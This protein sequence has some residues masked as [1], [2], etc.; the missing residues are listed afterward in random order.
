MDRISPTVGRKRMAGEDDWCE[1]H[2]ATQD[3]PGIQE[4]ERDAA[5]SG[6]QCLDYDPMKV[7]E[8]K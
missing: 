2:R 4:G 8:R 3:K 5:G 6:Q 1:A 7:V